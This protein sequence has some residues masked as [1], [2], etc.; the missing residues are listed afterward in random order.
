MWTQRG[1]RSRHRGNKHDIP[2]IGQVM[3]GKHALLEE[4]YSRRLLGRVP[5][6]HLVFTYQTMPQ[7]SNGRKRMQ[8]VNEGATLETSHSIHGHCRLS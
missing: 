7:D 8:Y 2:K 4:V 3:Q 1:D 5:D 6:H